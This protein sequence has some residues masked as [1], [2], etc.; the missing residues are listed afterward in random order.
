LHNNNKL[1]SFD[2][3]LLLLIEYILV[4]LL[5]LISSV[6][7]IS[8]SSNSSLVVASFNFLKKSTDISYLPPLEVIILL[9]L[10]NCS[11]Q[12]GH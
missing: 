12:L 9:A 8:T 11:K 4:T 10:L 7:I 1:K 6:A 5:N 2:E 3:I